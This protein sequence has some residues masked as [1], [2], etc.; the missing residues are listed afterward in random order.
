MINSAFITIYVNSG[1]VNYQNLVPKR[2]ERITINKISDLLD[3]SHQ[4]FN[5][6]RETFGV[7]RV[8]LIS[9]RIS[10]INS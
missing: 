9:G 5:G 3:G 7:R 4:M 10:G 6:I 2:K 1:T 8:L